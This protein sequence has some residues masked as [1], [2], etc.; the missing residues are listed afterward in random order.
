[1]LNI[2]C[3]R[4]RKRIWENKAFIVTSSA[5]FYSQRK[6]RSSNSPLQLYFPSLPL[7]PITCAK[8]T[9]SAP[10]SSTN[11]PTLK[12]TITKNGKPIPYRTIVKMPQPMPLPAW[13]YSLICESS[14][15]GREEVCGRYGVREIVWKAH[16][17]RAER[18][19]SNEYN[20]AAH[21]TYPLP[22]YIEQK[23]VL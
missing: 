16:R 3:K 5:I 18:Q 13:H 4:Y 15:D 1:M 23:I 19:H 17:S 6:I 14:T 21:D 10:F 11:Q 12:T 7:A 22:L 9:S 8:S 20:C 2:I